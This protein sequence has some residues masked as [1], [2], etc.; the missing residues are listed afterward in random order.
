MVVYFFLLNLVSNLAYC[1]Y[2]TSLRAIM[3]MVGLAALAALVESF[4]VTA[5]KNS[6]WKMVTI[7]LFS[8]VHVTLIIVDYFLV[9]QFDM[10][11][12]QDVIDILS[13]TNTGQ[14][15]DFIQSYFSSPSLLGV[16]ILISSLIVLALFLNRWSENVVIRSLVGLFAVVGVTAILIS[17]YGFVSYGNGYSI[18]QFSAPTRVACSLKILIQRQKSIKQLNNVCQKVTGFCDLTQ[19]PTIIV[20]IGESFS[21][22]H[23]SLYG[24]EKETFPLLQQ[25][26]KDGHLYVMRDVVCVADATH[27]NMKAIFSLGNGSSDFDIKPLFPAVFKNAGFKTA[28]YDNQ[29]ILGQGVTFLTDKELNSKL[30]DERNERGYTYDGEMLDDMCR[31]S[32]PAL[33][34]FHLWGQHYRYANRYPE[35]F[36][37][38]DE[39]DYRGIEHG[40]IVAHYD[41]ANL[42]N[43]HVLNEIITKFETDDALLVYFSDHGEEVYEQGFMG[44]GTSMTSMNFRYQLRVPMIIWMSNQFVQRR[45]DIAE[46]IQRSVNKP[47]MT[48]DVGHFLLDVA[49]IN[50][51]VFDATRSFIHPKFDSSRPRLVMG[52]WDYDKHLEKLL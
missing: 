36:H 16:F 12:N 9:F 51:D 19:A 47:L 30:F 11:C 18:P 40:D 28:M 21:V 32:N 22:Y 50:T 6:V 24:Y 35:S 37:R 45:G 3:C 1:I 33:Y 20:V 17:G 2:N 15:N 4:I 8:L 39:H 29:Y 38:F 7:V 5:W 23:C 25:R 44:H 52:G 42:Y 10:V 13:E 14:T 46:K 34:V 41:N 26:E 31:L 49:G 43:D 27:R 48:S